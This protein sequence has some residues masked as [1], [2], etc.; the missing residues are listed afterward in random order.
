MSGLRTSDLQV[1][2]LRTK[3]SGLLDL[4]CRQLLRI[5]ALSDVVSCRGVGLTGR[6]RRDMC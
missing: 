3:V 1:L 4:M 6:H 5:K 2:N